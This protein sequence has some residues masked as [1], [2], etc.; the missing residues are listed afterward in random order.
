MERREAG[1]LPGYIPPMLA[2]AAKRPPQGP[3]WTFEFKWDGIRAV[4][5]VAGERWRAHSRNGNDISGGYPELAV[6]PE[7]VEG[8]VLV[9][10]GELVVLDAGGR[11]DFG[12]LQ[13][14][15]HMRPP[16]PDL[17]AQL[18]VLYYPFDLLVL[19]GERI[20]GAP[21]AERRAALAE[22]GPAAPGRVVVPPNV[23]G[24]PADQ[25]LEVAR[26]H[27]LEGVVAKRTASR[28]E[29]GRRSPAWVKTALVQTHEVVVVGW[30]PG[31]GRRANGIGALLLAGNGPDGLRYLGD[32]GT[33]FT[34]R[35]L[36]ELAALLA[37]LRIPAPAVERIPREFARGAVWVQPVTVGEVE[38]R[39]WTHDGRLRHAAWRG[40]RPDKEPDEVTVP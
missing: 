4:V 3:G 37:P 21:Y 15:M 36:D 16:T 31:K 7:L 40:L 17:L 32:V 22:L 2:T 33:G 39:N 12:L 35:M 30:R 13:H 27:G 1:D 23:E 28:Y 26:R 14:R 9:L 8:R 25:V 18:P 19:D 20:T 5:A 10:D 34:D 24:L 6:L 38:F 29:P 11:P